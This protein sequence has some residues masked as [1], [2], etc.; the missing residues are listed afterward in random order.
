MVNSINAANRDVLTRRSFVTVGALGTMTLAACSADNAAEGSASDASNTSASN[1]SA[2]VFSGNIKVLPALDE[3]EINPIETVTVSTDDSTLTKVTVA[4]EDGEELPGELSADGKTWTSSE[5]MIFDRSYTVA[6]EADDSDGVSGTGKSTFATVSAPYEA[7]AL[8]N[9]AEGATYGVG[10][11]IE[12]IFSEPVVH[13]AEV[14]KRISVKGGGDQEG[15]FRWY[16]DTMLRYRPKDKW[17]PNSEVTVDIDLFGFDIGNGMIG[18]HTTSHSFK[19]WEKRYAFVDNNTKIMKMYANDKVI[20]E[21]PVTLGNSEWPSPVGQLVIKEHEKS[22]FFNPGSLALTPGDP[23]YYEP[24]W[25]SN[26][27]R[28]TNGG[29]FVHQALPAAWSSVGIA[30]VSHGCI[31]LLPADAE[32]FHNNFGIGDVVETVNTGY[33]EADPDDGY[34]DWNIPFEHYS[35]SS[36]TGN[37]WSLVLG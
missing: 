29:V 21:A 20:R 16:S 14:E 33:P 23:H 11:I 30:N 26:T 12:L 19:T 5:H 22:Y 17:A 7:N 2:S 9:F 1:S 4:T 36:W 35:D 10:Y 25:A 13:K 3:V 6:W 8:V 27:S 31:G 37:W 15:K 34:G 18:N 24:F 28:L 32:F